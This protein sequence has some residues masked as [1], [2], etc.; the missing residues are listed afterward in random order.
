MQNSIGCFEMTHE[1]IQS[2]RMRF[3][4]QMEDSPNEAERVALEAA[5]RALG[6][7]LKGYKGFIGLSQPNEGDCHEGSYACFY[8]LSGCC[9]F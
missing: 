6:R 2:L 3:L 5:V 1:Q 8:T 4:L 9:A 7:D